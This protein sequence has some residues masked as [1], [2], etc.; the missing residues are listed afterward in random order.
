MSSRSDPET[1]QASLLLSGL[2]LTPDSALDVFRRRRAA[3]QSLDL[4]RLKHARD[5]LDFVSR[6]ITSSEAEPWDR[7]ESAWE[8]LSTMRPESS[9][10]TPS[11]PMPAAP[12]PPSAPKSAPREE[13]VR[14][15][16]ER[17]LGDPLQKTSPPDQ[18][19][20]GVLPFRGKVAAP[21]PSAV[22]DESGGGDPLNQTAGIDPD[23][24]RAHVTLPFATSDAS[25]ADFA[26]TEKLDAMKH[27][28]PAPESTDGPALPPHLTLTIEQYAALRA[29]CS[30]HARWTK[31]ISARY[32]V[33]NDEERSAVDAHFRDRMGRDAA[34]AEAFSYHY[35]RIEHWA[36]QQKG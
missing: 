7:L 10:G 34:L 29:E 32:G 23:D 16:N 4:E 8:L 18:P 3:D 36:R 31:E 19:V 26:P 30:V 15:L 21:P 1:R 33:R 2:V 12:P 9:P 13:E 6:A 11:P 27:V 22:N 17:E 24:P 28:A 35:A 5:I 20:V 25:A 14:R